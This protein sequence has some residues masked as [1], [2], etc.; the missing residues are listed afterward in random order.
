VVQRNYATGKSAKLYLLFVVCCFRIPLYTFGLFSFFVSRIVTNFL[1]WGSR[2]TCLAEM[3]PE[4]IFGTVGGLLFENFE[5][6]KK[7]S[8]GDELGDDFRNFWG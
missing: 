5:V 8:F 2:Y 7:R 3:T 4:M 1:F 6:S